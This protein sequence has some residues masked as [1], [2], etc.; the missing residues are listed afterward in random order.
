VDTLEKGALVSVAVRA[1]SVL[2]F[3]SGSLISVD[4]D[5]LRSFSGLGS[6][7]RAELPELKDFVRMVC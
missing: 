2:L 3:A 7:S 4:L 6:T 5:V 1:W